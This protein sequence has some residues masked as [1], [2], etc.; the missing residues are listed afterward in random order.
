MTENRMFLK[1]AC[2]SRICSGRTGSPHS[3]QYA[4][5]QQEQS[6]LAPV[7]TSAAPARYG[8]CLRLSPKL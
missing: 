7:R 4:Y 6:R 3:G 2:K 1:S 8:F 5:P